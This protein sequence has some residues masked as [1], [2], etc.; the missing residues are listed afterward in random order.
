[1]SFLNLKR[2]QQKEVV[3]EEN[4]EKLVA[5]LQKDSEIETL[6]NNLSS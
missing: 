5:S 4:S 3:K 2:K 6:K 1:M